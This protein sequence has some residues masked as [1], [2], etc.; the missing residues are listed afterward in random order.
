[1]SFGFPTCA[2]E[3]Y[4]QL[5]SALRNAYANNVLL[6]AAASNNGGKLGRSFP[7]RDHSVIAIHSTDTNGNRS[8]FSPTAVSHDVN[9]ATVGE[10]VE[11]AWPVHL[12][13]EEEN[14]MFIKN[15][16]G[17][18]YATPIAAGISAFLLLYARMYLPEKAEALKSLQRMKAVL[19]RVA[20]KGPGTNTKLRD[21]YHF[22]DLSLYADSLFGKETNYI[23]SVIGDLLS[24]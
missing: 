21:G 23:N 14:P 22:I 17:T 18:S 2:V 5:E 20:E 13:D 15:R 24:S 16:S 6:F 4:A 9:L 3:G 19:K 1:M 12:C 11:S 10:A 8:S 7:A